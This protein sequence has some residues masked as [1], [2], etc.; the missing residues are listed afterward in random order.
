MRWCGGP[1]DLLRRKIFVLLVL[2]GCTDGYFNIFISHS[3]VM[4][5]LVSIADGIVKIRVASGSLRNIE[6]DA[7]LAKRTVAPF[8]KR[9]YFS[10]APSDRES[11]DTGH[12]HYVLSLQSSPYVCPVWTTKRSDKQ[13]T[14]CSLPSTIGLARETTLVDSPGSSRVAGNDTRKSIIPQEHPLKKVLRKKIIANFFLQNCFIYI[15]IRNIKYTNVMSNR[16][17][18]LERALASGKV[19]R[20]R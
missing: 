13:P 7:N 19:E 2:I 20:Q 9:V 18:F 11:L 4:K 3:Q 12:T 14:T 6:C 16:I 15:Y 8:L 17:N 10:S 5:L 1:C